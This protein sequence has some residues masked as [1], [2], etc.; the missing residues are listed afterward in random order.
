M[1]FEGVL[2]SGKELPLVEALVQAGANLDFQKDGKGDTPL[3]GAASLGAEDV[4]LMLLDAGARPDLRGLFGETALHWAALFGEDRLA[5][6]LIECSDLNLK[7]EKYGSSPL[8]WAI[9]GWSNPPDG[10]RANHR[11][12]REVVELL[13]AAKVLVEP[14]WVES[15]NVRAHPA[16]FAALQSRLRR[17]SN[18]SN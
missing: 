8:G 6:R 12:Q 1:L 13:I 16:I 10:N 14:D 3:I 4:G 17:A 5:A 9:H 11:R 18:E 7:D 2:Q 15:E